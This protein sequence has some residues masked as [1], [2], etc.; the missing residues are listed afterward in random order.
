MRDRIGKH[1]SERGPEFETIEEPYDLAGAFERST[2]YDA[3]VVDCLTL[4]VSNLMLSEAHDLRKAVDSMLQSASRAT[5]RL[6]LV[7]NEVGCSIVPENA[8]ARRFRDEA[9]ILNQQVAAIALEVYW[10]AFGC[11]LRLK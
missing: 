4:W 2:G 3:L 9:G 6:I 5:S 8:L 10:M 1:K 7:T 11:P